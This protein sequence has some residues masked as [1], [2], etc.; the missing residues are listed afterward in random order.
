[1]NNKEEINLNENSQN[2]TKELSKLFNVE[3]VLKDDLKLSEPPSRIFR[4]K[5]HDY[6]KQA[7]SIILYKNLYI[8]IFFIS[9]Y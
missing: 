9:I 6:Q 2:T 4:T 3:E 7:L 1:M 5:L 8:Y